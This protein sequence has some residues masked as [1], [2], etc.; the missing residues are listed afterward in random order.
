MKQRLLTKFVTSGASKMVKVFSICTA[1]RL[2]V[3]VAL[4]LLVS[5]CFTTGSQ[6]AEEQQQ[7]AQSSAQQL[8]RPNCAAV[9]GQQPQTADAAQPSAQHP[10]TQTGETATLTPEQRALNAQSCLPKGVIEI[11]ENHPVDPEIRQE[12]QQAVALLKDEQYPEAI[13]LLKAVTGKTSKFTGPHIN[14]AIAYIRTGEWQKAEDSLQKALQLNAA[15]PV[16]MNEM[17]LVYRKTGRYA[18]ARTLYETLLSYY[19]DFLPVR[20]NLGVLCDIYIQDLACAL[21]N[22]EA[23]LEGI[24]E[25]EK[26]K[27]WVADVKSRM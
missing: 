19:P 20:K 6:K 16:A 1:P 3:P 22:Y 26:V 4:S 12:F 18:E 25:D 8:A 2:V 15:H 17:G 27:I 14:L 23:Y 7:Q 24:P 9:A 11:V 21:E 10:A 5:A 13:R